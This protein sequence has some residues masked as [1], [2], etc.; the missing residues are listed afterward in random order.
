MD[1]ISRIIP[2]LIPLILIQLALALVALIHIIRH[3]TYK[4]GNRTIWILVCLL[5][6]FIGPIL[7]F[8]IGKG[9]E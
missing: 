2:L 3:D 5:V 9:D 8:I 6:N 7:Y 1:A 4:V